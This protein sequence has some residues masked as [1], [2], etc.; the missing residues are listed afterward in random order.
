MDVL[1]QLRIS[2]LCLQCLIGSIFIPPHSPSFQ[3]VNKMY[4]V[5][6][7]LKRGTVSPAQVA[8]HTKVGARI[9][10]RRKAQSYV[11]QWSR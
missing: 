1:P 11:S 5:S 9:V 7:T 10:S 3:R 6:L 4:V 8:M 2:L